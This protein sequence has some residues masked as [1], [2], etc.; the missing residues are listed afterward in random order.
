[1]WRSEREDI[2]A[3]CPHR[4]ITRNA[5]MQIVVTKHA[6]G[7]YLYLGRTFSASRAE[8]TIMTLRGICRAGEP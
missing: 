8:N 1:M 6:A 3:V 4:N 7:D 5:R 2:D